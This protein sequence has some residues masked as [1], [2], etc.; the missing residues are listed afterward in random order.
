MNTEIYQW[1]SVFKAFRT[2]MGLK[3]PQHWWFLIS[4]PFCMAAPPTSSYSDHKSKSRNVLMLTCKIRLWLHE[5]SAV[6]CLLCLSIVYQSIFRQ[7]SITGNHA[8]TFPRPAR[9]N[10]KWLVAGVWLCKAGCFFIP[11]YFNDGVDCYSWRTFKQMDTDLVRYYL[12]VKNIYIYIFI[13]LSKL[14]CEKE[15]HNRSRDF[16]YNSV[17]WSVLFCVYYSDLSEM[18]LSNFSINKYILQPFSTLYT[19]FFCSPAF[20][21]SSPLSLSFSLISKYWNSSVLNT[22]LYYTVIKQLL[23]SVLN[24]S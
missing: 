17:V 15:E 16:S 6:F 9:P 2:E 4:N 22:L 1:N 23:S 3:S 10:N 8:D 5:N 7:M 24:I 21:F 13:C 11:V 14:Y 20:L 12:V 19:F 18:T